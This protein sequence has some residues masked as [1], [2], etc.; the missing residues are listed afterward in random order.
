M[1][2]FDRPGPGLIGQEAFEEQEAQ[3]ANTSRTESAGPGMRLSS[4]QFKAWVADGKPESWTE[5]LEL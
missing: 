2:P 4:D 3:S 5:Y 1:P